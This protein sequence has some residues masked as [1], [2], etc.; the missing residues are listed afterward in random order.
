M[1]KES[2]LNQNCE[3]EI[4]IQHKHITGK[5]GGAFDSNGNMWVEEGYN[6]GK[7]EIMEKSRIEEE[8]KRRIVSHADKLNEHYK[9][10]QLY[11]LTTFYVFKM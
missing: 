3:E 1:T 9:A 5:T 11:L 6:A 8:N 4:G 2:E 10:R 7:R